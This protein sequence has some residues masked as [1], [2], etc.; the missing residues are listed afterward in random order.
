M[1]RLLYRAL[2]KAD[3]LA[4]KELNE[5]NTYSINES[6]KINDKDYIDYLQENL[7]NIIMEK[8]RFFKNIYVTRRTGDR[9]YTV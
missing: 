7:D 2:F 4:E 3:Q 9:Y 5:S 6:E 1:S 8:N